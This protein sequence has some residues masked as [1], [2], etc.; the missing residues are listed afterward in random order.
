MWVS[1]TVKQ[2]CHVVIKENNS[3][4]PCCYSSGWWGTVFFFLKHVCIF[5]SFT[6]CY[7]QSLHADEQ[8]CVF[9]KSLSEQ[10][11][12]CRKV[13]CVG[14]VCCLVKQWVKPSRIWHPFCLIWTPLRENTVQCWKKL[15]YTPNYSTFPSY[16]A[17]LFKFFSNIVFFCHH[18]VHFACKGCGCSLTL[19]LASVTSCYLRWTRCEVAVG[20]AGLTCRYRN[21]KLYSLWKRSWGRAAS[22][23]WC[24]CKLCSFSKPLNAPPSSRCSGLSPKS[25]S[26]ST[27]RLLKAPPSIQVMLLP[28]SQSTC[29]EDDAR[30]NKM[31]LTRRK[32]EALE[33]AERYSYLRLK[34]EGVR[35][36]LGDAV[37][38]QENALRVV[39]D[40]SWNYGDVLRLAADRHGRG[41]THAQ[42]GACSH[43]AWLH[44]HQ[45]QNQP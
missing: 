41:V 17:S 40:P 4:S 45:P 3:K 7:G 35:A 8:L 27:L 44:H 12:S 23:Q 25:S 16:A 21:C 33:E 34:A 26:S 20:N 43:P 24:M 11:R 30:K 6:R 42:P 31:R 19:L 2:K 32:P 28:Y 14:S 13:Q 10:S 22:L 37:V 5:H 36:K 29:T 1:Y 9:N 39:G 15:L 18:A 38:L